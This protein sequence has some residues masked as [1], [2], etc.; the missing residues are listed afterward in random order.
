MLKVI[1]L[2]VEKY[3]GT[4]VEG[5]N[6]N[7]KDVPAVLDRYHLHIVTDDN[8]KYL[9]TL[10]TEYT[11]CYSGWTTAERGHMRCV[12]VQV[13]GPTTHV[14]I[15]PLY[16]DDDIG[17]WAYNN[18]NNIDADTVAVTD[19]KNQV[20]S[21]SDDGGDNYYPS[22]GV[23]V[24]MSLFVETCRARTKRQVYMV[25]GPS[26]IGKSSLFF[27][28]AQHNLFRVV[29]ETDMSETLPKEIPADIVVVGNKYNHALNTVY[30]CI[31]AAGA[32][33]VIHVQMDTYKG[34]IPNA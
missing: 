23:S 25:T 34:D 17:E 11:E 29:Y 28:V 27:L 32:A 30:D 12:P 31:Q 7:F 6:C 15:H 8:K 9:A 3:A 5:S 33:D 19:I 24:D 16:I 1:G 10:W 13:F 26:G 4:I 20:F 22:G 2:R 21:Y 18:E 14:P